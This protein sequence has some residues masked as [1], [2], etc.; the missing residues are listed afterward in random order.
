MNTDMKFYWLLRRELWEHSSIYLAPLAVAALV[1]FAFLF[2]M[3][4]MVDTM[5]SVPSLDPEKQVIAVVTPYSLAASVILFTSFIV[6]MFYCLDSLYGER[7]D[8][9]I[10]FWKSM[11]VADRTTILS[12][13]AIPLAVLPILAFA[14]ALATQAILLALSSV[15]LMARG[16]ELA[17]MWARL[18]LGQITV[19]MFYGLFVHTLWYAP[20]YGWLLLVSAWAK[21][22]PFLWAILPI[23][24]ALV[25]ERIAFDTRHVA[26]LIQYRAMG[27]MHEAFSANAMNEPIIR[28]S[29]LDPLRFLSSTGLWL[30]LA[31]AAIFL[32]AA[33]WLR[34]RR[35]PI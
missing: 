28:I 10:L 9:S 20:L 33:I 6:A 34:R 14:I 8:R 31:F 5:R 35:E 21:R 12:K 17:T 18:P 30:G 2:N 22:A 11:P 3:H 26:S 19:V 24:A 7:R 32:T 16:V 13:L 4:S 27:A 15:V 29:Q 25:V 1:L 23:F